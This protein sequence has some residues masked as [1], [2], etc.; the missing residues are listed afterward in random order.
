M[1]SDHS[2]GPD[3]LLGFYPMPRL[4]VE[5]GGGAARSAQSNALIPIVVEA[6]LVFGAVIRS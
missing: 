6:S 3:D 5:A 1:T 2:F 4:K